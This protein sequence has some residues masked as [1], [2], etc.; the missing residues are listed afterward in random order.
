MVKKYTKE[1]DTSWCR[2]SKVLTLKQAGSKLA[3]SILPNAEDIIEESSTSSLKSSDVSINTHS[4]ENKIENVFKTNEPE[5]DN[6]S[7]H[8]AQS[9]ET[10][11]IIPPNIPKEL[12]T[13]ESKG[14][15]QDFSPMPAISSN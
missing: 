6:M 9:E 1:K 15:I 13:K 14:S 12:K 5:I 7:S 4:G 3:P 2:L 11:I 8:S 10:S